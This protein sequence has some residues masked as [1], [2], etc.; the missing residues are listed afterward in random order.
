M[1]GPGRP[2]YVTIPA[3]TA[4]LRSRRRDMAG[5]YRSTW[6]GRPVRGARP[7][8]NSAALARRHCHLVLT[9]AF[10]LLAGARPLVGLARANR[11]DALG[12]RYLETLGRA[13]RVVELRHRDARQTLADRALDLAEIR[14]FLRCD[15]REGVARQLGAR[16]AAHAMDVVLG[17]VRDVE[18]HDVR[19]GLDVDAACR[20]V[21]RDEDLE[22]SVLERGERL[23]ALRLAAVPVNAL[24]R[25]AVAR[26]LVRAVLRARERE[27]A[28]EIAAFEERKK[29]RE[30]EVLR[31]GVD[32]LRD[33]HGGERLPLHVHGDGVLQQLLRELRD[34]RR[35][36]GREEERL[37]V[38]GK[39]PEDAADIGQEAHVQHPVRLVE[40][41]DLDARELRVAEAEVVEK[42]A[43]RRDDHVDAAPE[44][45]LLRAHSDAAENGRA[46]K[47][48]VDRE[49]LEVLVDLRRQ[50]ARG[51]ED[52]RAR[53][54]ARLRHETVKDGEHERGG[55]TAARHRAGEDVTAFHRGRNGVVLD[56]RGLREAHFLDAAEEVGVEA[57]CG[58]RHERGIAFR[59]GPVHTHVRPVES[60]AGWERW[61]AGG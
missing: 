35:H 19:E 43:R 16:R 55:L 27:N 37:A 49:R 24:A 17:D 2:L 11:G 14:L 12:N 25:H 31:D 26:Q 51:R 28:L 60:P 29:Q 8:G 15:E 3:S 42:A 32:R 52:E 4:W 10:R 20:D 59:G 39:V 21:R 56:G 54:A 18:V 41:E 34:R 46:G 57:E 45:V 30:L 38:L 1:T 58:E 7:E 22:P 61:I 36:R 33:A 23:R 53:R 48:R 13:P 50:L 5:S 40:D 44:R 47:R 9:A 6:S